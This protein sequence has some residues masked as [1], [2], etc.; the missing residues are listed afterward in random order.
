MLIPIVVINE[1]LFIMIGSIYKARDYITDL[2][3]S[4]RSQDS[5]QKS[6]AA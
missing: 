2:A 6:R 4:G 1:M 3:A 5:G